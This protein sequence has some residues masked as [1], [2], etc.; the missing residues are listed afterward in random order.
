MTVLLTACSMLC[1]SKRIVSR[2]IKQAVLQRL[3]SKPLEWFMRVRMHLKMYLTG[4]QMQPG[5]QNRL[6]QKGSAAML[7]QPTHGNVK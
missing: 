3:I 4:I 2:L 5:L 7:L 1:T 6:E